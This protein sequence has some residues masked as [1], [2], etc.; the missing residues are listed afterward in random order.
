MAVND[1][2]AKQTEL[3][4]LVQEIKATGRKAI[5][6]P[7][8]VS[9]ENEVQAMVKQTVDELGGLDVVRSFSFIRM[10]RSQIHRPDGRKCWDLQSPVYSRR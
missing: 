5:A 3:E 8:D 7:G 2:L 9:K 10:T 6:V 4:Q 1:I